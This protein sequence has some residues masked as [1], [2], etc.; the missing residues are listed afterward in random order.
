MIYT[1]LVQEPADNPP[2]KGWTGDKMRDYG[3]APAPTLSY[4]RMCDALASEDVTLRHPLQTEA[5]VKSASSKQFGRSTSSA[6]IRHGSV[7]ARFVALMLV[8]F[9]FTTVVTWRCL[10]CCHVARKRPLR[11]CPAPTP[12]PACEVISIPNQV[13]KAVREQ[14][15]KSAAKTV[16]DGIRHADNGRR[17]FAVVL[18]RAVESAAPDSVPGKIMVHVS[19]R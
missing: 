7:P 15:S 2:A 1:A 8:V 16:H 10:G 11:F 12:K 4:M 13:A 5:S 9:L 6:P 14:R 19:R 17:E 3:P 18:E